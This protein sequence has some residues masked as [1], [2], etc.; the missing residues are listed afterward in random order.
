M[1]FCL[2]DG[3]PSPPLLNCFNPGSLRSHSE[4]TMHLGAPLFDVDWWGAVL[5]QVLPLTLP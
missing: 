5:L 4:R 3:L 2:A 1:V